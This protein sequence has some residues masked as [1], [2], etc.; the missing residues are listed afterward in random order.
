MNDFRAESQESR[1]A[2]L[3]AVKRVIDSGHY[4]LGENLA[5]F[6]LKWAKTCGVKYA[7]GVGNGMDAIEISL[8]SL[9]IGAG[10]EVITTPMTAFATVLGIMRAGATPVLADIDPRTA[11]MSLESA[12]RC[13]TRR[14]RAV[15]AVHLYGNLSSVE[16]WLKFCLDRGI[17]LIEDCAQSHLSS[18]GGSVAG[19]FGIAGAYSFYPTKNLGALGDAGMIVTSNPELARNAISLRNYGQSERYYHP[20][21][22]LNS[23]LDEIQAAILLERYRHLEQQTIRRQAIATA[24][25]SHIRNPNVKML[26]Q[27]IAEESHVYHLFVIQCPNRAHLQEHLARLNIQTLIHYPIPIHMQEPCLNIPRDPL[28]LE[29]SEHHSQ[30][31]ISIPCHPQLSNEEVGQVISG[32]NEF[33]T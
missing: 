4:I 13:I 19:S 31:C 24:Y 5:E 14:T 7:I 2:T 11:L 25:R 27:P 26:N 23:R 20:L 32:I 8:R 30:V 16:Q 29:N 15:L 18:F 28:G 12:Q 17:H 22:G 6:E 3:A 9:G 10:D 33:D 1:E 21:I